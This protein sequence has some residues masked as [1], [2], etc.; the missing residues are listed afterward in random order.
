V[1][2]T[3][4][5]CEECLSDTG[6]D[7]SLLCISPV[8]VSLPDVRREWKQSAERRFGGTRGFGTVIPTPHASWNPQRVT[9]HASYTSGWSFSQHVMKTSRIQ[10]IS[11]TRR[12]YLILASGWCLLNCYTILQ[13]SDSED[14][15]SS[16]SDTLY[17]LLFGGN[18]G[19][20][21]CSAA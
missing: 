16:A 14:G 4:T 18:F 5:S 21:K 13:S 17:Y 8:A 2:S 3:P 10:R 15:S 19:H 12:K 6:L 1:T 20:P 9:E 11:S 7:A